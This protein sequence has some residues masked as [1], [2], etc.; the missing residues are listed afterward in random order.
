MKNRKNLLL[1]MGFLS[2]VLMFNSCSKEND[3]VPADTTNSSPNAK[4]LGTWYNSEHSSQY[5][6]ST[7]NISIIDSTNT[8][9]ILFE[10]LYNFKTKIKA[11]TSSSSINMPSQIIDGQIIYGLGTF[12][13]STRITLTYYVNDGLTKDTITS[14]LTK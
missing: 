5:G 2:L 12:V 3:P 4:F 14:V 11:T 9:Y 6:A 1:L 8:T 13:N 10:G 7:Y